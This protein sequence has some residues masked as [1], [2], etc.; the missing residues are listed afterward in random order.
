MIFG[1]L[2]TIIAGT[3]TFTN[4][5][6]FELVTKN[7]SLIKNTSTVI[8]GGCRG[9]DAMA[10]DFAIKSLMQYRVFPADFEKYGPSGGPKRNLKMSKNADA[11]VVLWD[12]QSHGTANMLNIWARR[13]NRKDG[14]C[15]IYLSHGDDLT[16]LEPEIVSDFLKDVKENNKEGISISFEYE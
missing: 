13:K 7:S 11:L 8:S 9:V 16:I 3:R 12:G 1:G 5:V 15:E 10:V 6:I 4:E 2:K 14:D